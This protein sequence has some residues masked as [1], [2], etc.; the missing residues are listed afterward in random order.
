MKNKR[1]VFF[2][3]MVLS[4]VLASSSSFAETTSAPSGIDVSKSKVI[5]ANQA[6]ISVDDKD[7]SVI[8]ED[9]AKGKVTEG[10]IKNIIEKDPTNDG[11]IIIY[12]VGNPAI[13]EESMSATALPYFDIV[14]TKTYSG[15]NFFYDTSFVTSVAKGETY[16]FSSSEEFTNSA[17]ISGSASATDLGI[18]ASQSKTYTHSWVFTGPP[19][20]SSYNTRSFYIDWYDNGGVYTQTCYYVNGSSRKIE[21]QETG[22]FYEPYRYV[23]YSRDSNA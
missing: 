1:L 5:T 3:S 2:V 15:R 16:S 21:W 18:T 22:M 9:K 12:E 11:Q 7:Y 17:S 20:S 4:L 23:T 19:E 8:I 10:M 6:I 13:P 14:T